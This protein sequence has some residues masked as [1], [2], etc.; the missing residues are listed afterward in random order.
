MGD[1]LVVNAVFV[2]LNRGYV[3]IVSP[4]DAEAVK[5]RTWHC[6]IDPTG[7]AYAVGHVPGSGK[8]GRQE[9]MHRFILG[10]KA[11][12]LVDHKD[13]DG[14]N[15][16]RENLRVCVSAENA[17]NC[18]KYSRAR[19]SKFKG[20]CLQPDGR[21]RAQICV[22]YHKINL[23]SYT[24]EIMAARVYDAAALEHFGEFARLNFAME[25]IG[26]PKIKAG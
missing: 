25:A 22:A 1:S 16:T 19:T 2:P 13:G 3:A 23:G 15:N 20:V 21:W 6:K 7:R 17:R 5:A 24:T 9:R 4:E 10:A 26:Q 11:G 8:R 14:L 18:R 12:W